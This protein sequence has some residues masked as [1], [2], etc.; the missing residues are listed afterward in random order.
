MYS[1][2]T[3]QNTDRYG[4]IN[5]Y[6]NDGVISCFEHQRLS[7]Q[8]FAYSTDFDYL[9]EQELPCF[10]IEVKRGQLRLVV[11]HY[12]AKVIL[13]SGLTLEILPKISVETAADT[14]QS[15]W[16]LPTATDS[17]A[18]LAKR[19]IEIAQARQ[20][21]ATMLQDISTDNLQKELAAL[22]LAS[23]PGFYPPFYS[24][25]PSQL[26]SA[27]PA[28][29]KPWYEGLLATIRQALHQA[30]QILPSRYQT[31]VHN[32]PKAQGKINLAA[33]LKNNWHR[34]HYLYT[35]QAVF[36][37]DQLLAQ[38]LATAWQQLQKLSAQAVINE[39]SF[40]QQLPSSLQGVM[41]LPSQ[42]WTPIYQQ[43]KNNTASWGSQLGVVQLQRV[44][45]AIE[46]G[47]WLLTQGTVAESKHSRDRKFGDQ[48]P[49]AAL[50]INMNHAFERWVLGKLKGWVTQQLADSQLIIQPSFDWL[51]VKSPTAHS[52]SNPEVIQ[53]LVPDACLMTKDGR[54]SHVLDIKYKALSAATHVSGAD[55]QQ[56]Y[57]YQQHLNCQNAW[58][59]YPKTKNFAQ[60]L[61]VFDNLDENRH[62]NQDGDVSDRITQMSVI[63]FDPHQGLLL[64]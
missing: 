31:Q 39:S 13:P 57:S 61:D 35:E 19:K 44:T 36:E 12:L 52:L 59:I 18:V 16:Q 63:P 5:T 60:R 41:A 50:M 40:D 22:N 9:I 4:V 48:L 27:S 62:S 58:L 38:F 15:P 2:V 46:W 56:L 53:K 64:I 37:T 6:Q 34:P 11:S 45:H 26:A 54:I 51:H 29:D 47:W 25:I 49:T 43:L 28:L 55:W 42:S 7:R 10:G 24:N 33:Q 8:D 20:W 32:Q 17:T 30:A 3:G 1:G 14:H 21:V 23:K